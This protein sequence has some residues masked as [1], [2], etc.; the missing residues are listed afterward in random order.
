[1]PVFRTLTDADG[2]VRLEAITTPSTN[3]F[4]LARQGAPAYIPPHTV[5]NK[6][7]GRRWRGPRNRRVV[8]RPSLRKVHRGR[9]YAV[10]AERN[11]VRP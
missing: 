11:E 10:H 9:R 3:S 8:T 4:F 6:H 1:M 5:E 7:P 2:N